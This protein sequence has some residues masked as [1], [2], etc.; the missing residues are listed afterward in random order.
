M[1]ES[2]TSATVEEVTPEPQT[3]EV[4]T[5]ETK[6][7]VPP[8][9]RDGLS[10]D[11]YKK[12]DTLNKYGT[13]DDMAKAHIE[14]AS[15]IGKKGV[16]LPNENDPN[17][18]NRYYNELGRPAEAGKYENPQIEVDE[19][20]KEFYDEKG[21]DNFKPLA[22]KYGLT[23]KQFEGLAKEFTEAQMVNIKNALSENEKTATEATKGLMNEWLVDY[24]A[25]TKQAELALKSFSKG[26]DD[27]KVQTL[28]KDPDVKRMFFNVSK[29]ISE[30]NF[31]KG[32]SAPAESVQSL[33]AY[34]DSQVKNDGSS[35]Y[36]QFAPDHKAAKQKVRESYAKLEQLRKAGA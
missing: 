24:D 33:Q 6:P 30:D 18:V 17:D 28:M 22:H 16:V 32:V 8:T 21:L 12:N 34:I 26:I 31:R 23:Q 27:A 1:T 19:S 20:L 14:L 9:W 36:N 3:E 35:Y 5:E 2:D 29:V 11:D 10:N 25:N 13:I 7:V 15:M 4:K